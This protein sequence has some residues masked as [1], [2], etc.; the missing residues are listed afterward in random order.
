MFFLYSFFDS[1]NHE[2]RKQ[3]L[4]F[5]M[6]NDKINKRTVIEYVP[7]ELFLVIFV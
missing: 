2:R 4:E 1:N 6:Y 3:N 7:C 5:G